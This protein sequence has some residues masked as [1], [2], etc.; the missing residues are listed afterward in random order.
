V[1]FKEKLEKVKWFLWHGNV[2]NALERLAKLRSGVEDDKLL[3]D[4]QDLDEYIDRNQKYI[5]NYQKRQ[6]ANLPFTST[7]A[8]SSV[9]AIINV[10]QKDNKKMQ[11]SR[12]GAHNILQIR[13][14]RFSKTW[15]QDWQKAQE[16]IYLNAA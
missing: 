7:L 2:E 4:L 12:E 13:T 15:E 9:N 3:S 6:A 10:R 1:G 5:T 11:W 16:R 8:E 14:S